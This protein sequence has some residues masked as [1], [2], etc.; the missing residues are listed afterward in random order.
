MCF[1]HQ[2][3]SFILSDDPITKFYLLWTRKEALIKATGEGL[4]D[5]L[6]EVPSLLNEVKRKEKLF[7][8]NSIRINE[9]TA[10]IPLLTHKDENDRG[11]FITNKNQYIFK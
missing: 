8:I 4:T 2:E 1:D 3:S 9:T 11:S 10:G 5:H 7:K 6:N